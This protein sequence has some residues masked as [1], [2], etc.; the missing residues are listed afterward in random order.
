[1]GIAQLCNEIGQGVI[2]QLELPLEGT[3][4]HPAAPLEQGDR[5]VQHL[6]KGHGSPL[7]C[8]RMP[9]RAW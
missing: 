6:L 8:L 7:P 3:I 9:P 1:M 4:G 2:I 5:L